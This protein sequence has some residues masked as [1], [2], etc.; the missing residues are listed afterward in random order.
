MT[1]T[2]TLKFTQATLV[3]ELGCHAINAGRHNILPILI[4]LPLTIFVVSAV[5]NYVM[6]NIYCKGSFCSHQLCHAK[7]VIL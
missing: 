6:Q 1:L 4:P 5:A 2:N 7:Y 3:G